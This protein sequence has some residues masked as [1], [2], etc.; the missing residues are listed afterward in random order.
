MYTALNFLGKGEISMKFIITR[1]LIERK[2]GA[3][4]EIGYCYESEIPDR[5]SLFHVL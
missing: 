3:V 1:C 2:E 4:Q 5:F